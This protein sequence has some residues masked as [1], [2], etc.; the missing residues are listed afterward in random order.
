[1]FLTQRMVTG[2]GVDVVVH[3]VS[4]H[5]QDLGHE[6]TIACVDRDGSFG[7]V[8]LVRVSPRLNAV[9]DLAT[10]IT[11][12]VIVAHTPPFF[13]MLPALQP[14]YPCWAWEHGDP[15]PSLFEADRAQRQREVD[16]KRIDCYPRIQG[17][18]AISEFIRHDI[19]FPGAHV[20]PNGCDH[21]P[22]LGPK[23]SR[24]L[25]DPARPLRVG[26][27]MRLG[28]GEARYKGNA[29]FLELTHRLRA[30]GV[31]AEFHVMGR[32]TP[33]DAA[34][35]DRAG[36]R[37]H[38]NATDASK[39]DYLRQL[40]VFVSCSLWEGFNLPLVEAQAVGTLGL[41]LDTGAHPETTPFA[42]SSIEEMRRL[43]RAVARDRSLLLAHSRRAQA[44]VRSRFRWRQT[45][46]RFRDHVLAT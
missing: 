10:R 37:V 9:R 38:L 32:G 14:L 17:V 31:N 35:F 40:D 29:Q 42:L 24:S 28:A 8:R 6:V 21:A 26:A 20:I 19:G 15:M 23:T 46:E 4:R 3:N 7:D 25:A 22:D 43:V 11:P 13:A 39:W 44:H 2:Y 16:Q 1:L 5:V 41:A 34:T 12:S 18:I 45:A 27:L 30:D 33:A 36:F